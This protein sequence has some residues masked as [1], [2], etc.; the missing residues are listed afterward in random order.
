MTKNNNSGGAKVGYDYMSDIKMVIE[1]S[2]M[3][4]N[5]VL[6]LPIDTFQLM[7]KNQYISNLNQ[8][9]EGRQHLSDCE[10]MQEKSPDID[11]IRRKIKKEG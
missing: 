10:R 9:K 7:K 2:N 3:S 1:Y 5:E 11:A 4:Y 8:T 6:E